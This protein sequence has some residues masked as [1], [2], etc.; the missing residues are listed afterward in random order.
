MGKHLY[1][2]F[3]AIIF[4]FFLLPLMQTDEEILI[5][6]QKEVK[7]T[8]DLFGFASA[9]EIMTEANTNFDAL[10][11]QTGLYKVG[12]KAGSSRHDVEIARSS[13]PLGTVMGK[14]ADKT[15]SYLDTLIAQCYVMILRF[16]LMSQWFLYIIPF[17]I[18]IITHGLAIRNVKL[19]DGALISPII[20]AGGLH[21]LVLIILFPV[22]YL[23]LPIALTP[24]FIPY[25]LLASAFPF[26]MVISNI[27]K[28]RS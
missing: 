20:Y 22:L 19:D 10:F 5:R 16:T 14:F 13:T 2:W 7:E 18:G 3:L 17:L 9:K 25:W 24:M 8:S 26:I 12:A 4:G 1:A 23:M 28:M 21:L 11:V 15:N 6:V 27:Q